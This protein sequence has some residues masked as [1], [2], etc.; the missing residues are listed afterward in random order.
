MSNMFKGYQNK[1]IPTSIADCIAP[2]S[3]SL[4]LW[5]KSRNSRLYHGNG[6]PY[7]KPYAI[8]TSRIRYARGRN[9]VWQQ[10]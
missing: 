2:N 5:Q 1:K 6:S 4:N 8:N 10:R 3:L 9:F 7:I